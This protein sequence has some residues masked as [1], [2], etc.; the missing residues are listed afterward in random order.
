MSFTPKH[1]N[2]CFPNKPHFC[3][4]HTFNEVRK[5][6]FL[7]TVVSA[8]YGSAGISQ[9]LPSSLQRPQWMITS[10]GRSVSI[11]SKFLAV[12]GHF[13]TAALTKLLI[14]TSFTIE[15]SSK[16]PSRRL[17]FRLGFPDSLL[18]SPSGLAP[19]DFSRML[20]SCPK[21]PRNQ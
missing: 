18:S 14:R 4:P 17:A 11:Y 21:A 5:A 6:L 20:D 15:C 3:K 8:G 12:S 7:N 13:C 9:F 10:P 1:M 16:K 19:S 2:F